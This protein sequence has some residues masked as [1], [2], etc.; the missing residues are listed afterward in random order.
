M[1]FVIGLFGCSF[2]SVNILRSL[3]FLKKDQCV[4]GNFVQVQLIPCKSLVSVFWDGFLAGC[5]SFWP[6]TV[7]SLPIFPLKSFFG[8]L[9]VGGGVCPLA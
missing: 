6:G 1:S 3:F 7:F 5:F 2:L 9:L 8:G 4:R